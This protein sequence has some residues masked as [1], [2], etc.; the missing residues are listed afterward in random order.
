MAFFY[1]GCW[2]CELNN[3]GKYLPLVILKILLLWKM[4][5]E[6]NMMRINIFF[7]GYNLGNVHK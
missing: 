1:L 5:D 7:V 3:N 2:V 4:V 6:I